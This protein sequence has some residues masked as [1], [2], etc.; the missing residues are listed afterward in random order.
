MDR[1]AISPI[2]PDTEHRFRQIYGD[3]A[4]DALAMHPRTAVQRMAARVL[5]AEMLGHAPQLSA[6]PDGVPVAEGLGLNLSLTHTNGAVGVMLGLGMV[7]IDVQ[8]VRPK[9]VAMTDRFLD[10]NEQHWVNQNDNPHMAATALWSVKEAV[11]KAMRTE[12]LPFRDGIVLAGQLFVDG[13]IVATVRHL[14]RE[15]QLQ[16]T[17]KALPGMAAAWV[18]GVICEVKIDPALSVS[19]KTKG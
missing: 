12:G 3:E 2:W 9:I 17:T 7:G 16:L 8:E 6:R 14:G 5:L 18:F 19:P 1:V 4:A 10:E 11:Y 13:G 15:T